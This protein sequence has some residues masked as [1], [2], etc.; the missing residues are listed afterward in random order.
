MLYW[1]VRFDLSVR[2]RGEADG[3]WLLA[4]GASLGVLA[5]TFV[6]ASGVPGQVTVLLFGR[7]AGGLAAWSRRRAAQGGLRMR[8][9][10]SNKEPGRSG[11]D[12]L[13]FALKLIDER[14]HLR[15]RYL[16]F[17]VGYGF[18]EPL[19]TGRLAGALAMLS[20]VV[21]RPIELRQRPR[22]NFEDGWEIDVDGRAIVR[23]WLML[24]DVAAYVVRHRGHERHQ[25]RRSRREPAAGDSGDL[26]ERDDHRG[27][28]ASR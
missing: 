24:L 14:R 10:S 21:P 16:V 11:L 27:A 28:P 22:W 8:R 5:V 1:P 2:A 12:P 3:R 6:W 20:A 15:L 17:D 7:K 18:R 19:L 23:P 26:E 13:D 4:G 25:D 9:R